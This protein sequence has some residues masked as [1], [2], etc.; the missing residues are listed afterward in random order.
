MN[1][2]AATLEDAERITALS[3]QLGYDATV[4]QTS[5]RLSGILSSTD[6]CVYVVADGDNVIGW[7]HGIYSVRVESDAFVEI[8]GLVIDMNYRRKGVG[9]MLVNEVIE[10]SRARN[11]HKIRVRSNTIRKEAHVFYKSMGFAETK[12]QKIFDLSLD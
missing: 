11:I 4:Q 8:G 3:H 12:E 6:N 9:K 10:W 1:L 7:I 2:R 5:A